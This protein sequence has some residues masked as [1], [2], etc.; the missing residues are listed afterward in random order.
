MQLQ[1]IYGNTCFIDKFFSKSD[2]TVFIAKH[3]VL[4][5]LFEHTHKYARKL[6]NTLFAPVNTWKR[7]ISILQSFSIVLLIILFIY[8]AHTKSQI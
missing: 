7:K 6:T 3:F 4:Q 8:Q 2:L 1:Y 5:Q